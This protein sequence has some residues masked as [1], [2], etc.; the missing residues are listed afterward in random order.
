LSSDGLLVVS[1]QSWY[2]LIASL[3]LFAGALVPLLSENCAL[4]QEFKV[5]ITSAIVCGPATGILHD[6]CEAF[7]TAG[8]SKESAPAIAQ[9]AIKRLSFIVRS[10]L[11]VGFSLLAPAD[12]ISPATSPE[13]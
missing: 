2:V 6:A 10:R 3:G 7:A 5:V 9:R 11:L 8:A 4:K 13:L 12:V 1:T